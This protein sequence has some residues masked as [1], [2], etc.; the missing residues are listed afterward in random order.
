VGGNDSFDSLVRRSQSTMAF[1]NK[2]KPYKNTRKG[3]AEE[4]YSNSGKRIVDIILSLIA[5]PIFIIIYLIIAPVIY[6]EDNGP[7]FFEA[8]RLGKHGR[9]FRMY[10]FRSMKVNVTDLRNAD[11]STFSSDTDPRVTKIGNFIRVTSIDE[12]PQILNV[13]K[14]DM[15]IVGPRP[16]L[17]EHITKYVGNEKRKLEVRPGITGYNQAYFRNSVAWKDRIKHDIYYID[18]LTFLMDVKILLKS[19]ITVLKREKVY[20]TKNKRCWNEKVS[21]K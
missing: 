18:R 12:I 13:L 4:M 9:I 20:T 7:V 11:G 2:I 10:K 6:L 15:S 21:E 8:E 19:I 16:D 3:L 17:P 1:G 14:G 5:F